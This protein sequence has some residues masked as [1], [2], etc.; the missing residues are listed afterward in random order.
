MFLFKDGAQGQIHDIDSV[1]PSWSDVQPL[2]IFFKWAEWEDCTDDDYQAALAFVGDT[3]EV[4][5]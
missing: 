2:Q 5:P 4:T 1:P 3:P